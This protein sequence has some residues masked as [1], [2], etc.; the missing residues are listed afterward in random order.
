MLFKIKIKVEFFAGVKKEFGTW[1]FSLKVGL[2]RVFRYSNDYILYENVFYDFFRFNNSDNNQPYDLK[3]IEENYK[4]YKYVLKNIVV[5]QLKWNTILGMKDAF[6][7]AI[8]TGILWAVKGNILS[9]LSSLSKIK[10]IFIDIRPDFTGEN[11]NSEFFCILNIS[12]AHIIIIAAYVLWLR[13][14]RLRHGKHGKYQQTS[15]Y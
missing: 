2:G 15:S 6:Q 13:I 1:H 3:Y 4:I 5:E 9:I 8:I 7:T 11:K 14:R 10:S 12:I